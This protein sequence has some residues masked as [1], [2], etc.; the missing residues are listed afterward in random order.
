MGYNDAGELLP[1]QGGTNE[2]CANRLFRALEND[3]GP[4]GLERAKRR[5]RV[6]YY[7]AKD[8]RRPIHNQ[9]KQRSCHIKLMI[10]DGQVAVQGSANQDTQSWFH[11][12][13][14]NV[15]IDSEV[16][17]RAWRKG[18]ERNQNTG[19]VPRSGSRSSGKALGRAA[20]D[21][22]WYDEKEKLAEGSLGINPGRFSWAKGIVGAVKRA[23]GAGGF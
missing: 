4:D 10:V 16:I 14:L 18:L 20:N 8:Q 12:Q 22:C 19:I 15:M 11:S 17:C 21:G 9:F 3:P 23:R 6:H 5:L 2:M 1:G 13:E 7:V